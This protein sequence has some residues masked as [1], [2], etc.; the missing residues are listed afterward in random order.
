MTRD[1]SHGSVRA[2]QM[3]GAK[4][5]SGLSIG[6]PA[7]QPE[8]GNTKVF[9]FGRNEVG[10]SIENADDAGMQGLHPPH[11]QHRPH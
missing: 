7:N 10:A 6:F 8:K 4:M 2:G 5:Q 11:P 3:V 1:E 9:F